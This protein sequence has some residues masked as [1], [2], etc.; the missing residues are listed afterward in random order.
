M[1]SKEEMEQKLRLMRERVASDMVETPGAETMKC[2]HCGQPLEFMDGRSK[3][4][5][6]PA[7]LPGLVREALQEITGGT[8]ARGA[9]APARIQIGF[10]MSPSV[11]AVLFLL[12]GLGALFGP[13]P[14]FDL[15]HPL[16]P[17]HVIGFVLLG[18]AA[19][20]V[21]ADKFTGNG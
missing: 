21:I 9:A 12:G 13:N 1:P 4:C 8:P 20:L 19:I 14:R 10:R 16:S 15:H 7:E 18:V 6:K 17:H 11:L 3:A 5:G 2:S